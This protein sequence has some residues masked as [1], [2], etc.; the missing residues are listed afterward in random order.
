V[1]RE[2]ERGLAVGMEVR[3][4]SGDE[5]NLL[6]SGALGLKPFLAFSASYGRFSPHVDI[7]YQW[8]GKSL[9][10]GSVRDD[11]KAKL[12]SQ[13]L[14]AAGV[15][16]G[17]HPRMT[18]AVD[19][20]GQRVIDSPRLVRRTFV[21]L[22]GAAGLPDIGFVTTTYSIHAGSAGFKINLA[23]RLLATFNVRFHLGSNGLAD[24]AAP[25]IGVEY[26]F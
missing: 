13:V 10:A 1:F 25:L 23:D 7:G 16:V 18:L 12:P 3:A 4:P 11:I 24:R 9:L 22:D 6:G 17:V 21:P 20:L 14:Y 19:V 15:D 26:G 8:N 5:R 2:A